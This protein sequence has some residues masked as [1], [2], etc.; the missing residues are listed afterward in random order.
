MTTLETL[1]AEAHHD[2]ADR[3]ADFSLE[4]MK[5]L[6]TDAPP[7]RDFAAACHARRTAVVC[8]ANHPDQAARHA[9]RGCAAV[10][11]VT[12]RHHGDV[13]D[14]LRVRPV[15]E[16]PLLQRDIVVTDY[17]VWE[18]R[19]FGAD[20]L[21]LLPAVLSDRELVALYQLVRD[22]GMTPVVEAYST[23]DAV[24]AGDIGAELVAL[25]LVDSARVAALLPP[26]TIT[27]APAGADVVLLG[28]GPVMTVLVPRGVRSPDSRSPGDRR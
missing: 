24:R 9:A 10:S 14:L 7:V 13:I 19:A 28:E 15:V 8:E 21:S 26:L 20:A 22:I 4:Q 23:E 18:A 25:N 2:T 16:I 6:T 1:V 17:Q 3:Q 12:E 5:A 11:V 27:L